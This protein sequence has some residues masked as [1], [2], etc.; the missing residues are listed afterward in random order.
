TSYVYDIE[1][2]LVSASGASN[3]ELVYDP[4]GRLFQVSNGGAGIRRLVYD[5]DALIGEY[6]S[7]GAM[8]HRYIHGSEKGADDP[9]VWYDNLASGWRRALLADHQGSIIQ[10]A[11]MYGQ[12][13]AT[14]SYDPWGI[15]GAA[16]AGRFGYTGQ[17]WVP[18][19]GLWYYKAR[20]YSPTLGRFLQTDPIGYADQVNLYA[21]VGNDP[22]SHVDPEGAWSKKVHNRIFANAMAGRLNGLEID[23][24]QRVSRRQDF[25]GPN[26]N[27]NAAH[28]LR[29]SGQDIGDAK[30][31]FAA[32]VNSQIK[33]GRQALLDNNKA[34]A[35]DAFARAAHAIQDFYSPAHNKGGHPDVYR[36]TPGAGY[37]QQYEEAISQGHSPHEG[38][39]KEDLKA[40]ARSGLEPR[41]TQQT[42]AV[43]DKICTAEMKNARRC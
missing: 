3:A 27:S 9:L 34:L 20:F 5:D 2:R 38:V 13:V 10:V 29:N 19:L 39:G 43:W 42:Q 41:I 6:N 1:N 23:R 21:Y 8:V 37:Q 4:L 16:P 25:G 7:A 26:Q 35:I 32:Y 40:L 28:F 24:A 36:S 31:A 33:E 18:E 15:P 17:A 30:R 12:P 22:V 11:D 14:N